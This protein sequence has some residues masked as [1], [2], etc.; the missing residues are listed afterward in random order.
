MKYLLFYSILKVDMRPHSTGVLYILKDKLQIYSTLLPHILEYHFKPQSIEHLNIVNKEILDIDIM[1]FVANNTIAPSNLIVV[2]A[3]NAS[4]IQ[5]ITHD[6]TEE[7]QMRKF[8]TTAPFFPHL[9]TKTISTPNEKF[10]YG[11]NYDLCESIKESFEKI[12]FSID[13]VLPALAFGDE[14][15]DKKKLSARDIA[16]VFK[17]VFI[18][19]AYNLIPTK[20]QI[21][22][23]STM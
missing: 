15:I 13:F 10:L 23:S 4:H 11:V 1:N 14:F 5:A 21:K 20:F 17:E 22:K 9:V 12:G 7:E 6:Q 2:I 8:M 19:E 18:K 16:A 3:N